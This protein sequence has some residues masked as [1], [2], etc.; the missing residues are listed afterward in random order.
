MN[1][2]NQMILRRVDDD[3]ETTLFSIIPPLTLLAVLN[4]RSRRCDARV[5]NSQELRGREC[6]PCRFLGVSAVSGAAGAGRRGA[7]VSILGRGVE[8]W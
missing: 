4:Y 3:I 8:G 1:F 2:S 5:G 6:G 7:A